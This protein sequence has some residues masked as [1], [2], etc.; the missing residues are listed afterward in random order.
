MATDNSRF[1]LLDFR[2]TELE[3]AVPDIGIVGLHAE[4]LGILSVS[5]DGD[6][7]EFEYYPR[8]QHVESERSFKAVASPSSAA[9]AAG[10]IY[11]SSIEKELVPNLLINCCKAFKSG[12]EQQDQPFLENGVQPADEDKQVVAVSYYHDVSLLYGGDMYMD[13]KCYTS[14][15]FVFHVFWHVNVDVMKYIIIC[16]S[17]EMVSGTFIFHSVPI[18]CK[19]GATVLKHLYVMSRTNHP[20]TVVDLEMK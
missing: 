6:P 13:A 14:Y 3:I 2:F 19:L 20:F 7:T 17:L 4:N 8:P 18:S 16:L 10:S 15:L 12:S 5:V 9:D 1:L 11:M